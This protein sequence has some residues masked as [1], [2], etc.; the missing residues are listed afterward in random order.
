MKKNRFKSKLKALKEKFIYY[1]YKP[2]VFQFFYSI[3]KYIFRKQLG[4]YHAKGTHIIT[5]YMGKGKTLLMNCLINS[6][7]PNKYFF[8]S[9][10]KEFNQENV[11]TF[12]LKDLFSETK[13]NFSIPTTD[14]Y[15]RKLYG[16]ILDEINLNFN[17]RL[18]KTKEY[19]NQFIGL[20]EFLVSSR[21]QNV[22]RVYFIGQKMELQD[23]QLQSL[24]YYWHDCRACRKIP[25]F[26]IFKKSEKVVYRPYKIIIKNYRKTDNDEYLPL[27]SKTFLFGLIKFYRFKYKVK[28]DDIYTYNTTALGDFYSSL[29]QLDIKK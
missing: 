19:N 24:F 17:R 5:G 2:N 3:L 16:V 9:N 27:P 1:F 22:D 10:I 8:I 12:D 14:E 25:S 7:D 4:I 21:H 29:P 15:G 26:N 28:L 18:N 11:Y 23:S 13:Q 20:V 6:V